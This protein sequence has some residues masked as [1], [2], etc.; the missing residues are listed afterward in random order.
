MPH[1]PSKLQVAK[2]L[3]Q[4]ASVVTTNPF[5]VGDFRILTVSVSTQST[6]A[7]SIQLSNEE[8]VTAPPSEAGWF[9][10]LSPSVSSL[11]AIS[12]VGARWSRSSSPSGSSCTIIFAGRA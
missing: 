12:Q 4:S 11:F 7:I 6:H 10:V 1:S 8:G 5:F 2:S 9:T 3:T